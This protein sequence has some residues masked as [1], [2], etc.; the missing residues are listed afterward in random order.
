[1]GIFDR[2]F[3]KKEENQKE[4]AFK[5]SKTERDLRAMIFSNPQG[6]CPSGG[7]ESCGGCERKNE[8]E[9]ENASPVGWEAITAVFETLYP[10]QTAPLRFAPQI[11]WAEGGEEPLENISVYEGKDFFHFVTYGLSELYEK[12]SENAAYSGYGFEFTVKLKKEGLGTTP[13]EIEGE[14]RHMAGLL[15]SLAHQTF[16]EGR[17]FAPDQCIFLEQSRG[18]DKKGRSEITGFITRIDEAGVAE[19]PNGWVKFT[20][21]IG[22]TAAELQGIKNGWITPAQM[23]EALGSDCTDYN[24]RS[25][26]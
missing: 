23:Y 4:T 6:K 1:M 16:Q 18:I 3:Q 15:Q 13:E 8:Q 26:L 9:K 21:L 5:T 19:T 11:S 22:V 12:E 2:L 14:L 24:R 25:M 20:Q 17:M 7:C 10:Q